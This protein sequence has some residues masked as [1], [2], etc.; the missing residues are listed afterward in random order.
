MTGGGL[1]NHLAGAHIKGG[2]ER[3][4]AVTVVFEAVAL[5]TAG[6]KRQDRVEPVQCLNGTLFIDRENSRVHWRV[7]VETDNI[8]RLGLEVRIVAGHIS[9]EA[10][11]LK[12][13]LAPDLRDM[14]LGHSQFSGQSAGAPLGGSPAGFA[15]QSPVDDPCFQLL[16]A[17][18][19]LTAPMPAVES[20]QSI[21]AETVPPQTHGIDTAAL[22]GADR[23]QG[24]PTTEIEND[25]S[26]AALFTASTTAVAHPHKFPA[27]RRTNNKRCGHAFQ[28]SFAVSA[29]NNS[30]H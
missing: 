18:R 27:F 10:M 4:S 28:H 11:G 24:K 21:L 14:R 5:G 12:T 1:P 20:S 25:A 7:E 17:R 2:V 23:P 6:R 19:G 30:L 13:S 3:E 8:G 29:L 22:A 15:V 9:P 16:A 26:P